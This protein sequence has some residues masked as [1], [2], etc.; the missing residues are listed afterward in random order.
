MLRSV[1][2]AAVLL[3]GLLPLSGCRYA[4]ITWTIRVIAEVTDNHGNPIGGQIFMMIV[5]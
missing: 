5:L 2:L 3:L 4:P 1:R